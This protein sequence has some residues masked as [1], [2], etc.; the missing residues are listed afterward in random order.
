MKQLSKHDV[1]KLTTKALTEQLPFQ[2]T[3]DGEVIAL[4]SDVN[5]V[6]GESKASRDVNILRFSKSAQ[7]KGAMR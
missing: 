6:E 7:A 1:N 5:R 2:I 3:N 4:V